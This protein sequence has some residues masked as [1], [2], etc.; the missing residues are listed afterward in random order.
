VNVSPGGGGTVAVNGYTPSSYPYSK[1]FT[2]NTHVPL[3]AVPAPGYDFAS[4]NGDLTG[5]INPTSIQMT[6][7]KSV[8][9]HFSP[10]GNPGPQNSIGDHVWEDTNA[11]G[12]QDDNES[13]IDHITVNLYLS[14]GSFIGSTTTSNGGSYSF[15]DLEPGDYFLEFVAPSGYVFSPK[16]QGDDDT[17]DSDADLSGQTDL[18][19]LGSEEENLNIDAGLFQPDSC[20]YDIPLIPGYNLVSLPLIPDKPDIA[21]MMTGLDFIQVARYVADGNPNP[22]DWFLYNPPPAPSDL[23]MMPDGW[24]YWINMSSARVLTFDGGALAPPPALLPYYDV[25]IGWNLIGFTSTIPRTP[26][27]YL[28]SI[29]GKYGLIYGFADG[30]YFL[31]GSPGH[32]EL[33]PGGGYWIAMLEPGT[34][35]PALEQVIEDITPAEAYTLIL[36]NEQN[37]NFIILDVRT[38]EEYASSYIEDAINLD[39]FSP[40]FT[41]VLSRL[42]KNKTYLV[43]CKSGGRSAF[44]RD[45]M[46]DLGFREVYNML[47]GITQWKA[48]GY[49]VVE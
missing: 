5:S 39:Y 42:A 40:T 31:V 28:A 14:D 34:I 30:I 45:I 16:N 2:Q 29:D 18:V 27:E 13:G 44:T 6:C 4:W 20:R 46:S 11:N 49:P 19:G 9:A 36:D 12:I 21:A 24:G 35:H 23:D 38:P 48:E 1:R 43:Y 7:S 47:G 33:Q 32:E 8:T 41:E 10:Q 17:G 25:T 22:N 26:E 37:L 15:N 3:E